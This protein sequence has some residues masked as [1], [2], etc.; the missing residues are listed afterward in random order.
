MINEGNKMIKKYIAAAVIAFATSVGTAN[1]QDWS[2]FYAGG[3]AVTGSNT[4]SVGTTTYQNSDTSAGV[5]AGY[6]FSTGTNI[7]YGV[8]AEY[9]AA[10]YAITGIWPYGV[11]SAF[12][13]RGRVGYTMGSAMVYGLL[14]V[15]S[16]TIGVSG[17]S[18]IDE[19]V[20]GYAAGAGIEYLVSDTLS[21]RGELVYTDFGDNY[22]PLSAFTSSVQSI[23]LG[24]AYHF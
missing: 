23:R 1:A 8:E 20:T 13:L 18:S 24:A 4:W 10:D 15:E 21:V 19:Q 3:F 12:G 16:A 2:G 14:G 6:N 17:T 7:V 9:S 5:F 11:K 22:A